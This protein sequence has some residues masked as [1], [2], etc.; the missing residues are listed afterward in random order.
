MLSAARKPPRTHGGETA[1]NP[2]QKCPPA[3]PTGH[4]WEETLK[5]AS[6]G[7]DTA[8]V[9]PHAGMQNHDSASKVTAME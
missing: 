5:T 3:A 9:A 1:V 2:E 4:L 8:R 6:R 7:A